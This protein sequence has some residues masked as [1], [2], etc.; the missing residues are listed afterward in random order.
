[1]KRSILFLLA[2]LVVSV[3]VRGKGVYRFDCSLVSDV[4]FREG[5]A[6]EIDSETPDRIF[7]LPDRDPLELKGILS[8]EIL[9]DRCW[10]ETYGSQRKDL[11]ISLMKS[12]ER[13]VFSI[14]V[15]KRDNLIRFTPAGPEEAVAVTKIPPVFIEQVLFANENRKGRKLDDYGSRIERDNVDYLAFKIIYRTMTP[16][17]PIALDVRISDARGNVLRDAESPEA[18]TRRIEFRTG[19]DSVEM[20]QFL[21]RLKAYFEKGSRMDICCSGETLISMPIP[22]RGKLRYKPVLNNPRIDYVSYW[23]HYWLSPQQT[24]RPQVDWKAL[25]LHGYTGPMPLKKDRQ[26]RIVD[27]K[28][29][30]PE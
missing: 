9:D 3:P 5:I 27:W 16:N 24:A 11:T 17:I 25:G 19:A 22:A 2:T 29:I 26:L 23:D 30:D 15:S 21:G 1:M 13:G 4:Q 18:C 20:E 12:L 6:V 28:V 10:I 7:S 8:S 14:I